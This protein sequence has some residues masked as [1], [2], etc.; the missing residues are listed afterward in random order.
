MLL[1]P[2]QAVRKQTQTAYCRY[3]QLT[4]INPEVDFA[5]V[6]D[7][8][9]SSGRRAKNGYDNLKDLVTDPE[10]SVIFVDN[11]N[12]SVEDETV[13]LTILE[14]AGKQARVIFSNDIHYTNNRLFAF[15]LVNTEHQ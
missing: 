4:A 13:L 6:P 14:L 10:V 12:M 2:G 3:P 9:R 5:F 1:R 15:D 11:S 8:G 7:I